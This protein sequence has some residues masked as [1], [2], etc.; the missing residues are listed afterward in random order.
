[1]PRCSQDLVARNLRLWE[2]PRMSPPA[3][4]AARPEPAA[5]ESGGRHSVTDDGRRLREPP[6]AR[7]CN[8]VQ[9][10]RLLAPQEAGSHPAQVGPEPPHSRKPFLPE[11]EVDPTDVVGLDE[12]PHGTAINFGQET[13]RPVVE[14]MWSRP[15]V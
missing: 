4:V 1:M 8:A 13:L 11:T 2:G 15:W 10:V 12:P 14:P 7:P 5:P 6:P 3:P 9:Q